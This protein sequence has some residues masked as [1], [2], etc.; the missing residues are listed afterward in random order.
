MSTVWLG[1]GANIG[2]R[3][4]HINNAIKKLHPVLENISRAPLYETSPR[5][6]LDQADFL[7][8]VVRG[9]TDLSPLELLYILHEIEAEGGRNRS[10]LPVKPVKGP[11][12]IDIDIL[13][14]DNI[15]RTFTKDDGG[16]LT[17]P[18]LSMHQRLFVLKPLLDLDSELK[19][20]VDDVLWCDKASLVEDQQVKLYKR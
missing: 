8:T 19:D 13:L 10:L 4:N 9:E 6:F 14:Y 18:H 11:R 17:I 2:D 16:T 3:L 7:N 5:D 15:C 20:P 1:L 12:I